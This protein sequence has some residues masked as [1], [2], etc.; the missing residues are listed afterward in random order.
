MSESNP[1]FNRRTDYSKQ[2]KEKYAKTADLPM[3]KCLKVFFHPT[4]R[5]HIITV[6]EVNFPTVDSDKVHALFHNK[7]RDPFE[8]KIR[9]VYMTAAGRFEARRRV[10]VADN[11]NIRKSTEDSDSMPYEPSSSLWSDDEDSLYEGGQKD[12]LKIKKSLNKSRIRLTKSKSNKWRWKKNA[13]PQKI[14]G[15]KAN[16]P[17][18]KLS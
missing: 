3:T 10:K 6:N 9:D 7:I 8:E 1:V 14:K 12:P 18:S 4:I 17:F 11:P 5:D 2:F 13:D 16:L 15:M